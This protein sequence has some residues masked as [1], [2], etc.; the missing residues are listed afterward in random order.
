MTT[1]EIQA[2]LVEANAAYHSLQIGTSARVVV[3]GDG[4]RVEYTVA[5][6]A[7]LY[8]Y[9]LRLQGMLPPV[10]PVPYGGP[11]TFTF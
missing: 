9:I 6:R 10:A 4:Q 7:D 8:A 2:L 5:N 3:D 11:A 1:E